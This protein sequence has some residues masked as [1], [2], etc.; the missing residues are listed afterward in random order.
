M[1]EVRFTEFNGNSESSIPRFAI[2]IW[3]WYHN[4]TRYCS[5]VVALWKG[6]GGFQAA[7]D[8]AGRP[9][10]LWRRCAPIQDVL[11]TSPL[12]AL[13]RSTASTST[14]LSLS[15]SSC[16]VHCPNKLCFALFCSELIS[17]KE[18][19]DWTSSGWR[20]NKDKVKKLM[21]SSYLC[22]WPWKNSCVSV[23]GT[24]KQFW[25]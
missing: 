2:W 11:E 1:F 10:C 16:W 21:W 4:A 20:R 22:C 9:G 7:V 19:W 8:F 5:T 3:V 17:L 18:I 25:V 13:L 12:P 6:S 23:T 24:C 14:V 15:F